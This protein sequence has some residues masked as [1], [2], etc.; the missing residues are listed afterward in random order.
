MRDEKVYVEKEFKTILINTL[1]LITPIIK[2][3]I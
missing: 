2:H 1:C 3:C